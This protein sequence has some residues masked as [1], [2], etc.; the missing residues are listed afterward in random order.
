M[1]A[2]LLG[3]VAFV[4]ILPTDLRRRFDS[5]FLFDAGWDVFGATVLSCVVLGVCALAFL[6]ARRRDWLMV[7]L[8]AVA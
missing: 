5:S 4:T 1:A 2:T 7:V 6:I 8:P 3:G